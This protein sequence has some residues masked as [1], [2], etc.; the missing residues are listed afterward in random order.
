MLSAAEA[1]GQPPVPKGPELLEGRSAKDSSLWRWR[2][3]I[4][5]VGA[6]LFAVLG[7][8]LVLGEAVHG[9]DDSLQNARPADLVAILDSLE[10]D[11]DK[12]NA[13]K[14][15]LEGELEALSSGTNK[16]ALEKSQQRLESL[17]VLAGTT[18]VRGAGIQIVI[19]DSQGGV[20]ASDILDTIQELRDAGAESIE[21][22][23]RRVVVDTWFADVP[24]QAGAGIVVSG[25]TRKSPYVIK[26]IGN[27][28]TL[29]TAM[30]IPGG[31][32]DTMRTAGAAFSMETKD[33]LQIN[34]TVP[35]DTPEY[36]QPAGGTG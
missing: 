35:L 29:S 21:F 14:R 5:L 17:Q 12:L 1:D 25:D 18:P 23:D 20:E 15:L 4:S 6:A 3:P 16:E 27:P 26:A 32:A 33:S 10:G 9:G 7:L 31:V 30:E 24:A 8:M 34:S 22:A 28:D 11:I 36:A 19:A 2:G 13:E